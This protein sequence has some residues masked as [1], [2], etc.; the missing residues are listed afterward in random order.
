MTI[1][2]EPPPFELVL[3]VVAYVRRSDDGRPV[4][5][6]LGQ[7]RLTD[8]D[9]YRWRRRLVEH[10]RRVAAVVSSTDAGRF[11]RYDAPEGQ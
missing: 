5:Y 6:P 2:D 8:D 10:L 4:G 7:L 9:R 1:P 3:D 11:D